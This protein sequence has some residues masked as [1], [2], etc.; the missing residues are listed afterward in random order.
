MGAYA[1]ARVRDMQDTPAPYPGARVQRSMFYPANMRTYIPG[2]CICYA[3]L[4]L[5]CAYM[6]QS[7]AFVQRVLRAAC[8]TGPIRCACSALVGTWDG[9]M[10]LVCL[11]CALCIS[12]CAARAAHACVWHTRSQLYRRIAACFMWCVVGIST[13]CVITLFSLY[14]AA[15]N[16]AQLCEAVHH[17]PMRVQ[18][19][20]DAYKRFGSYVSRVRILGYQSPHGA[21]HTAHSDSRCKMFQAKES[22]AMYCADGG[23]IPTPALFAR[24]SF[25]QE[26]VQGEELTLDATLAP[27]PCTPAQLSS[28]ARGTTL[29]LTPGKVYVR[30]WPRSVVG[31]ISSFRYACIEALLQLPSSVR[32]AAPHTAALGKTDAGAL[33]PACEPAPPFDNAGALSREAVSAKSDISVLSLRALAAAGVL[34]YRAPLYANHLNELFVTCDIAHVISVSGA[35]LAMLSVIITSLLKRIAVPHA[36]QQLLCLCVC[37]VFCVLSGASIS[38]VRACMLVCVQCVCSVLHRKKHTLSSLSCV[39]I[40]MIVADNSCVVQPAFI[41][42]MLCVHG[43]ALFARPFAAC[44]QGFCDSTQRGVISALEYYIDD[45]RLPAH[46]RS[47]CEHAWRVVHSNHARR[48]KHHTRASSLSNTLATTIATTL[49]AQLSCLAYTILAFRSVSVIGIVVNVLLVPFIMHYFMVAA[50]CI[51]AGTFAFGMVGGAAIRSVCAVFIDVPALLTCGVLGAFSQVPGA[52]IAC[53]YLW[54]LV[55]CACAVV[56]CGIVIKRYATL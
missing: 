40:V 11:V 50:V 41:L 23:F 5:S 20:S 34:G 10:V 17:A 13:G 42:S 29:K 14:T 46:I 55:A 37:L 4:H 2:V 30:R 53:S 28:I 47:F 39:G 44:L 19:V 36:A 48:S 31:A 38:V 1:R 12:A 54:S 8:A 52:S 26:Y 9:R 45:W 43:I 6:R 56:L 32:V 33:A 7:F 24:V 35:H 25:S 18:V 51:V 16:T 3:A 21:T 15:R 22:T 27:V 49:A